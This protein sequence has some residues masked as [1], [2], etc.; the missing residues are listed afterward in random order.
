MWISH[1]FK[2]LRRQPKEE[3]QTQYFFSSVQVKGRKCVGGDIFVQ[4]E[5]HSEAGGFAGKLF[6]LLLLSGGV[7]FKAAQTQQGLDALFLYFQPASV[8]CC[9]FD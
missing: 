6:L 2:G 4:S 7:T 8:S 5:S 1:Q 9:S 3:K